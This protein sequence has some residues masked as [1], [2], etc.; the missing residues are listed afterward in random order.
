MVSLVRNVYT[1]GYNKS[2]M[3]QQKVVYIVHSVQKKKGWIIYKQDSVTEFPFYR[4]SSIA[5]EKACRW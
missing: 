5:G 1:S 2:C 3:C 4:C